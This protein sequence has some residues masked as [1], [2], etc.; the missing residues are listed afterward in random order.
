MSTP[1]SLTWEQV[2]AWRL[3]QQHLTERVS[4][5]RLLEVANDL[6]GIQAQV[7]SSAELALWARVQDMPP[8]ALSNA[9]WKQ[10][11]LIKT[12]AMRGALHLFTAAE[13]PL[14]AATLR[15]RQP[16]TAAWLKYYQL[17][18]EEPMVIIN[19][20][21]SALDGRCLTREQLAAEVARIT[22]LSRLEEVLRSGWGDL[23]KPAA[24][25]GYLCFGPNQERNV[26]FVRPDQ[27]LGSWEEY[28]SDE[29]LTTIIRRYLAAYGPATYQ[30]FAH[31]WGMRSFPKVR[32][33]FQRLGAEA[34][35]VSVEGRNAWALASMVEQIDDLPPAPA[36]RLL[37][38]FD[39]YTIGALPHIE[40]LLPGPLKDRISRTSGWISPV[41]LVAGRMAGVWRHEKRGQRVMMQIDPFLPLDAAVKKSIQEEADRLGVFLGA[42]V[43]VTYT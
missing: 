31:W 25:Q 19:G 20:V 38:G 21:R 8:D 7:L 41:L 15:T 4:P 28:D 22:G 27:W 40:Y 11:V 1:L 37:P 36:V 5:E 12:W 32:A 13:F 35:E 16:I 26:T 30:D 17:S 18:T 10:R 33:A 43:E 34:I 6:I 39:T 24:Y 3:S 23:L 2:C 9:L 29:A 14:V 42:P